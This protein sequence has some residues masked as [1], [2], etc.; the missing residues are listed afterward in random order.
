[1]ETVI[2]YLTLILL[3][4]FSSIGLFLVNRSKRQGGGAT[5]KSVLDPDHPST[6]TELDEAHGLF[7]PPDEEIVR[8]PVSLNYYMAVGMLRQGNVEEAI[9]LL[10]EAARSVPGN[11]KIKSAKQV[12]QLLVSIY[13]ELGDYFK[14]LQTVE[15]AFSYFPDDRGFNRSRNRLINKISHKAAHPDREGDL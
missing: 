12:F 6:A 13:E 9:R 2:K 14:A 4:L 1:V 5:R 11:Q 8:D 7:G 10:E 3:A 15:M